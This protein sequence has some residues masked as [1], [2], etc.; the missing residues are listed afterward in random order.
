MT[1]GGGGGIGW[2][3]MEW[4]ESS[5]VAETWEFSLEVGEGET[6][7][8]V[9]RVLRGVV[10][11]RTIVMLCGAVSVGGERVYV[12]GERVWWE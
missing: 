2:D 4:S 12:V 6:G 8:R 10:V 11:G 5:E 7:A 9:R 1:V 3:V